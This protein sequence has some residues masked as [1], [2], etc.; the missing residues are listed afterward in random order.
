MLDEVSQLRDE[1]ARHKAREEELKDAL[2][3]AARINASLNTEVRSLQ[4]RV[5]ADRA[6]F[7]A[8]ANGAGGGRAVAEYRLRKVFRVGLELVEALLE[9]DARLKA[10]E[11]ARELDKRYTDSCIA[12]KYDDENTL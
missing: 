10:F 11:A 5:L 7:E 1:L 12:N 9:A 2:T 4:A 8:A 3:R 6:L